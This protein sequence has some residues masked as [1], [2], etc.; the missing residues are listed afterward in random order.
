MK[1][2]LCY[3][4]SNTW[5]YDPGTKARFAH[6]VRWTG[7]LAENL[8]TDFRV[9]EEG[10][11]GRTTVWDDPIEGD[12]NGATYLPPCLA[13]HNPI[14]AVVLMLGTNDLKARFGLPASDIARG[15]GRLCDIIHD[16]AAG[17]D[18]H[19]PHT[20]LMAPPPLARLTEFAEMFEG[21]TEKALQFHDQYKAVAEE[22]G[23]MLLD[24][25]TVIKSSDLD[26]I[27]FDADAH[28]SLGVSVTVKL[29]Q[30]LG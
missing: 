8:G 16:C 26:G 15:A 11:N 1:T 4:D 2:V 29:K 5:G 30:L 14:D 22:K 7:V 21:G 27:H 19:R 17:P 3:G 10:L 9:V 25:G 6:D 18:G 13:S 23:V 12:K 28:H 24:V 20:L